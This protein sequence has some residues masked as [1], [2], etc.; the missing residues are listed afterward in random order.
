MTSLLGITV[1]KQDNL[2][3]WYSQVLTKAEMIDYYDVSGCYILLPNSYAI[4]EQIQQF[5]DAAIKHSGVSNAYFPLFVS[6]AALTREKDHIEGFAPEVAWVT[7]AGSSDLAEPIAI[8]PTSETI[9]YPYFSRAIRSHRDLPLRLNQWCNVVRWEFKH[10]IPFLRSREF[11]WQEGHSAF[12]TRGE[13]DLE[14]REILEIYQSLLEDVLAIPVILGQKS[15]LEKFSGGLYTTTCEAFIPTSGR[16]IQAAT[17][18]CLGQNFSRMFDIQFDAAGQ[19]NPTQKEYVWQNSWGITTRT[20]GIMTMLH[21]D[22]RGLVL[23]PRVAPIQVLVVPIYPRGNQ[24]PE[25]IL[26]GARNLVKLLA[27]RGIRVHGDFRENYTAPYKFNHWE[28]RGVPIRLEYGPQDHANERVT[29]VRRNR[30][31][32]PKA[33]VPLTDLVTTVTQALAEIQFQ[34]LAAAR[35]QCQ[36]RLSQVVTWEEF[37]AA[38]NRGHRV[39]APWCEQNTCEEEIKRR[40]KEETPPDTSHL[41]GSAKSLCIPF[42]QPQMPVN[43]TCFACLANARRYALFGRSY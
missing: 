20:I 40:S 39:L 32:D 16:G 24:D 2:S 15:E 8:R 41:S 42:Q 1:R 5:L 33:S 23:P 31:T 12:A 4:W 18:H 25:P 38:L 11:L 43:T 26:R 30:L 14:V 17:S 9:I 28:L 34:L 21:G 13:A 19:A 3:D 22:D 10:P 7:K 6:Q 36:Q 35:Q 27:E 29:L 37:M